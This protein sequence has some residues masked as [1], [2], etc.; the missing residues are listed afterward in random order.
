M[1]CSDI[2]RF[3]RAFWT[4]QWDVCGPMLSIDAVY[5]DPLLAEPMRGRSAILDV[6]RYCHQWAALDPRLVSLFGDGDRFCAEL[7]VAG[8]IV[9]IA[10][11]I[12]EAAVGRQFDFA[13]AD[14]FQV[15]GGEIVRMSIYAD[16]VGF[17]AQIS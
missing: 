11:G 4:S 10:D 15:Q 13:E 6:F 1:I 8:T 16:V 17:Q 5:E 3:L 12:P 9:A 14:V 7:R 2:E